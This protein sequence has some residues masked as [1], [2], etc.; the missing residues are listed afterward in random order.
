VFLNF[1]PDNFKILINAKIL[2]LKNLSDRCFLIHIILVRFIMFCEVTFLEGLLMWSILFSLTALNKKFQLWF[3]NLHYKL[4]FSGRGSN[5]LY[6]IYV[7]C[8][9]VRSTIGHPKT[10]WHVFL[11]MFIIGGTVSAAIL[12]PSSV[13][14]TKCTW[15]VLVISLMLRTYFKTVLVPIFHP[16]RFSSNILKS[17]RLQIRHFHSNRSLHMPF[18]KFGAELGKSLGK[19]TMSHPKTSIFIGVV[20]A[21]VPFSQMIYNNQRTSDAKLSNDQRLSDVKIAHEEY[22]AASERLNHQTQMKT[23]AC[24][25]GPGFDK[26][27]CQGMTDIFNLSLEAVKKTF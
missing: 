9:E 6:H 21:V 3:T 27:T 24:A 17:G 16:V 26:E 5:I 22:L 10:K 11:F 4:L 25:P 23:S 1:I 15:F 18:G 19:L 8:L 12:D 7:F 14:Y 13:K 2:L 20:G